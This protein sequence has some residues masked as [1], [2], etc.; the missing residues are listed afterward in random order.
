MPGW[1]K[2]GRLSYNEPEKPLTRG[3]IHKI[4]FFL[5]LFAGLYILCFSETELKK[6]AFFIYLMS[7]LC[8]YATSSV[9]HTTS[10]HDPE[11]EL[12]LQKLDH[13]V[14]I[15]QIAGTYTPVCISHMP[16]NAHFPNLILGT[17]W[18]L[19]MIGA[20]KSYVWRNPPKVFNVIFYFSAGL[21]IIPYMP[22]IVQHLSF[23]E[24]GLF[25]LGGII[26]LTGGTIYGLERP[27]P[28]PKVFGFHEIFH[29]CTISAN[30][31]FFIP[32]ALRCLNVI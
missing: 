24:W 6:M 15:L 30:F 19:T 4:S 10:W 29:C 9:F 1:L 21:L 3:Y 31:C 12:E 17:I 8:L 18:M 27:D 32:I 11:A 28:N 25:G 2:R 16:T 20:I 5:Y 23:F 13:C 26:Y 7:S 22:I 14:I